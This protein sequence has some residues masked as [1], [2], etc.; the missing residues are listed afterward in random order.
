V[1]V[2]GVGADL[3]VA[4]PDGEQL[5]LRYQGVATTV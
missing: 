2:E 4:L 1:L 5:V 3:V